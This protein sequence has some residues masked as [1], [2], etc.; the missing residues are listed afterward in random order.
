[1]AFKF[2]PFTSTFDYYEPSTGTPGP[3]GPTGIAGQNGVSGFDGEDGQDGIS[4]IGPQG[5]AGTPAAPGNAA[6]G[7]MVIVNNA[8]GLVCTLQ[9][10]P[11]QVVSGWVND[12]TNGFTFAGSALTCKNAGAYFTSC[13]VTIN[14][15]SSNQI[16]NI[17]IFRNGSAISGHNAQLKLT[18]SAD[19]NSI[20]AVGTIDGVNVNDV[21]TLWI[22]NLTSA[23]QTALISYA[24][25]NITAIQG[26]T[27][28]T[29]LTG[30]IGNDGQDGEDAWFGQ[31]GNQGIQG[32]QGIAGSQGLQGP[33]GFALD[34]EDGLDGNTVI[35]PQGIQ[36]IAGTNGTNGTIGVNGAVG[37][38]GQDGED[39]SI[40]L[41]SPPS[42][43]SSVSPA[44]T[45]VSETS[46]SQSPIV[47][48]SLN[49]AREDHSHGTPA[50]GASGPWTFVQNS[51]LVTDTMTIPAGYQFLCGR[52]FNNV[53]AIVNNGDFII[54]H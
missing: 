1:M 49:Y 30:A 43:G 40:W 32:I 37:Q 15:T 24:S 41:I 47:G 3:Q 12:D 2:N 39:G 50:A 46:A 20:T 53:G 17:Q 13:S 18:N 27:G 9:N 8:T 6:Y 31:Q 42:S 45:V 28:L 7:E 48:V 22:T 5:P 11:Y 38:D 14:S 51:T 52:T 16:Y 10:T 44:T 25:F 19:V 4:I 33:M 26:A 21:F 29:G 36:G 35:G 34:G 23:G 54:T